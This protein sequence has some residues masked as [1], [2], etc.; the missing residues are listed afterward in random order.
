MF[1]HGVEKHAIWSETGIAK[2]YREMVPKLDPEDYPEKAR[3]TS[4]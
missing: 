1:Q 2:A 3:W 4:S